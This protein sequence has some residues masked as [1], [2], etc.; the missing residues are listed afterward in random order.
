M[1][2]Y[3]I[4]QFSSK[5][6]RTLTDSSSPASVNVKKV[7]KSNAELD[8]VTQLALIIIPAQQTIREID[9]QL[10]SKVS[11]ETITIFSTSVETLTIFL[12]NGELPNSQL[13]FQT[14]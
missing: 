9:V 14:I 3:F 2:F 10:S 12:V 4:K 11:V 1:R 8:S 13:V 5:R 7:D 6:T